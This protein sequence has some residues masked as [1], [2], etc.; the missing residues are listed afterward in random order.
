MIN[1][2]RGLFHERENIQKGKTGDFFDNDLS[3][4]IIR[5][6]ISYS[7]DQEIGFRAHIQSTPIFLERLSYQLPEGEIKNF[8]DL[9]QLHNYLI[10]S[11]L[12]DFLSI[13]ELF[14]QTIHEICGNHLRGNYDIL[15]GFISEFNNLL[16][17]KIVPFRI[18]V[19]KDRIFVNRINSPREEENKKKVY[20]IINSQQ[21]S[22]TNI[23]F[24]NS[25]VH[26]AKLTYP[27]SIE[28]SYLALEKYLKIKIKNHKLD[29]LRSYADF[30][31]S[32]DV[33]RGI[34]KTNHDKI[35][36]KIS[37]V[38]KIR[39]EIKSHSNK[40]LFDRKDF[41]QETARFQLNEVMNLIIL[42]DSFKEK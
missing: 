9:T 3:S 29:A 33:E 11:N 20:E 17:L 5:L 6:M 30:K 18:E 19:R 23:H 31:K 37:F 12:N 24:T 35:K 2:I 41:L 28:E 39:S 32:F 27:E 8:Y 1:I 10:N 16:A 36:E 40:N 42:L 14:I 7:I 34:F 25:L 38:Y 21:F 22:E 26:F 4:K 15:N 13:M